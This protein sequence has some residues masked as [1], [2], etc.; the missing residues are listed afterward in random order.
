MVVNRSQVLNSF[1]QNISCLANEKY[2]EKV[3]VL[4]EGPEYDDIDDT[5]CDFFD[6]GN[7]ILEN[8]KEYG[9][10]ENQYKLLMILNEKL[11]KFT[12]AFRVYSSAQTTAQLLKLPQWQEIREISKK[13]LTAFNY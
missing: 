1:I 5:V 9:I 8:Y 13:V 6:D 4:A 11:R 2:Q 3:W 7:P 10:T 12:D